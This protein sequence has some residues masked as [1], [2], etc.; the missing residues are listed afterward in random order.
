MGGKFSDKCSM[1]EEK[2]KCGCGLDECP[3]QMSCIDSVCQKVGGIINPPPEPRGGGGVMPPPDSPQGGEGGGGGDAEDPVEGG[4]RAG[5]AP[6]PCQSSGCC[7]RSFEIC[8]DGDACIDNKCRPIEEC[9]AKEPRKCGCDAD[10][11][12]CGGSEVCS[13]NVCKP[14]DFSRFAADGAPSCIRGPADAGVCCGDD[15]VTCEQG[16]ICHNDQCVDKDECADLISEK[17][18]ISIDGSTT[19]GEKSDIVRDGS[20]AATLAL[21]SALVLVGGALAL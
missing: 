4:G 5:F 15:L 3:A 8:R 7:G 2:Q 13:E 11:P 12:F 20:A 19:E 9:K 10:E 16:Q 14:I 21:S 17:S 18:V 1:V 6:F